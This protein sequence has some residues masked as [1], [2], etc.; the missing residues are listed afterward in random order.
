MKFHN[1]SW[2]GYSQYSKK[3]AQIPFA[4]ML[5][6]CTNISLHEAKDTPLCACLDSREVGQNHDHTVTSLKL[7]SAT[8]F[9]INVACCD[10]TKF[11]VNPSMHLNRTMTSN[12]YS[13]SDI[14]NLFCWTI[15]SPTMT[16]TIK[17]SHTNQWNTPNDQILSCLKHHSK[18]KRAIYKSTYTNIWIQFNTV[19]VK[20][21]TLWLSINRN[22]QI[23][24]N[25]RL[26]VNCWRCIRIRH[27]TTSF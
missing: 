13:I 27:V 8:F 26:I 3:F 21:I 18:S 14:V 15:M 19:S 9:K 24:K 1:I 5:L 2:A 6:L 17:F 4:T 20:K 22:R 12:L 16:S 25:I 11:T 23:I 10:S 7:Q